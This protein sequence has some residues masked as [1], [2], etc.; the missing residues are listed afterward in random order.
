MTNPRASIILPTWNGE[1]D[2]KLLLPKLRAQELSGGLEICAIDSSSK[3]GTVDLLREFDVNFGVIKASEFS[4]AITRNEIVKMARGEHLVFVS[5]DVLPADDQFV[6]QLLEPFSD[7][8]VGGCYGRVL[9]FPDDDPLT[10][11]TVIDLPEASSEAHVRDL[12]GVDAV[13]GLSARER[14]E[15]LRFNN[16]ASAIRASCFA[17]IPF[18]Q[19][20]FGEDFAWAARALTW[21]WKIAYQPSAVVYHAHQYSLSK[22]YDRYRVDAAFHRQIHGFRIRPNV[23]SVLRGILFEVQRDVQYLWKSKA[24]RKAFHMLRSPGLRTAM[25]LGQYVGSK[26]D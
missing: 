20:E 10:A 8:R 15:Y 11:R 26:E 17:D 24:E 22:A 6:A 19:T 5:Q 23:L 1:E 7:E 14:A 12:D 13:W 18:P 3:D 4:H 25:I 9:P 16:V 21:G 2:L